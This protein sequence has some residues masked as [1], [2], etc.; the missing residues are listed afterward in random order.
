ME[1]VLIAV[2]GMSCGGCVRSVTNILRGLP[3]VDLAEVSL[4]DKSARVRFDPS[5]VT[6]AAMTKA[7]GEAGFEAQVDAR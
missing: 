7:I 2:E 4:A 3:G 5:G 1:E 6:V